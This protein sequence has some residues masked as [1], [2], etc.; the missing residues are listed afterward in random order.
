MDSA[1]KYK[2]FNIT[3]FYDHTVSKTFWEVFVP[4]GNIESVVVGNGLT[5][6]PSNKIERILKKKIDAFLDDL[7]EI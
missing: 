6:T 5:K 3:V 1:K 2:C 7:K 4:F